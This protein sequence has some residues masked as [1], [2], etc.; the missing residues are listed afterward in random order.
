MTRLNN[1]R[2]LVAGGTETTL[3]GSDL[4]S[5]ELYDPSTGQWSLTGGMAI[6]AGDRTATLLGNGQVLVAG[7]DRINHQ[8]YFSEAELY[9]PVKGTFTVTATARSPAMDERVPT[10]QVWEFYNGLRM[11]GGPAE[12]GTYPREHRSLHERAPSGRAHAPP[13]AVRQV[14]ET[15]TPRRVGG[16]W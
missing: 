6:A 4:S 5:A 13:G 7:G 8:A 15:V 3:Q 10:S 11:L 1:G 12:M 14:P 9:D 2:V 16:T